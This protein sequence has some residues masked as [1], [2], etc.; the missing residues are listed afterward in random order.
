MIRTSRF[1]GDRDLYKPEGGTMY[2]HVNPLLWYHQ[3]AIAWNLCVV[4]DVLLIIKV[5]LLWYDYVT[6]DVDMFIHFHGNVSS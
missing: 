3:T 4:S 2:F 5:D 1:I 6:I